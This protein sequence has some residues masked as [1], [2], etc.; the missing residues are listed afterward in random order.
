MSVCDPTHA[1]A[2]LI[3]NGDRCTDQSDTHESL[4]LNLDIK[5]FRLE[6]E[7]TVVDA[8]FAQHALVLQY[9]YILFLCIIGKCSSGSADGNMQGHSWS[10]E[11]CK[12]DQV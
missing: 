5:W 3:R 1:T 4:Q 2:M 10:N 9:L 6:Q 8:G 7:A 11:S 12:E